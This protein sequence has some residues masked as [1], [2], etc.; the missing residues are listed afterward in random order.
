MAGVK[1][2]WTKDLD[3]NVTQYNLKFVVTPAG[4]GTP[5]TYNMVV[6]RSASDDAS[7]YTTDYLDLTPAP[8]A[9]N[10]GD[11]VAVFGES[12]D[13][14]N[15]VS[16]FLPA[17]GSPVTINIIPPAPTGPVNLTAAQSS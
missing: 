2:T 9:L 13:S 15:Q 7:G 8:P 12:Q 11:S 10:N 17:Q 4:G 1:V 3:T 14:F 5:V 16:P 6:P